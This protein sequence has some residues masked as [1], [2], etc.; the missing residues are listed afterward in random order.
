VI[1]RDGPGSRATV[2]DPHAGSKATGLVDRGHEHVSSRRGAQPVQAGEGQ[3]RNLLS[4]AGVEIF[5][6][7]T[8]EKAGC[9]ALLERAKRRLRYR[10][11]PED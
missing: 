1:A 6:S 7:S 4:G 9:L 3:R 11:R 8:A 10:T 2:D 5:Q